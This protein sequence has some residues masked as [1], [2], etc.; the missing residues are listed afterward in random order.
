MSAY[1][2][3][4]NRLI[5]EFSKLPGVGPKSAERMAMHVLKGT[6]DEAKA[7]AYA[8]VRA[9]QGLK[10]CKICNNL[11]EAET[12]LVCR[13]LRRDKRTI[14]VVEEP[15]DVMAIEKSG[16]YRGVYHVLLGAISPLDGRGPEDL[17]IAQ[18]LNRMKQNTVKEIIIAT[19]SDAQ[20]E[21]TALYLTKLIKPLGVKATRIACGIPAGGSLEYADQAT[22]SKA[23]QGRQQL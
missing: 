15:K 21:T 22:L 4:L 11:S 18:L 2:K 8:L 9:K 3:P 6:L 19:G 12:C 16:A 14:C 23:L 17:K 13:D 20:G 10:Y 1:A 7:F 5:E